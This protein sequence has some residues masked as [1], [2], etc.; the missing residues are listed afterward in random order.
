M[1]QLQ[2]KS[3]SPQAEDFLA[4]RTARVKS[5]P[6]PKQEVERLW[7]QRNVKAFREIRKTLAEMASGRQRCMYCEDSLGTDIEHFWPKSEFPARA[8]TWANYLWAC[9]HCNS[10][11]KRT[12]F[13]RDSRG[14]PLL[15]DPTAEEPLDH[16]L[17][18]PTT[19]KFVPLTRKGRESEEVFGLNRGVLEQ[20]RLDAW[21][22]LQDLLPAY[23]KFVRTGNSVE[24]EKRRR[25]VGRHPFS[26]VLVSLLRIAAGRNPSRV[27][28]PDCLAALREHPEIRSWI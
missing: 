26:S 24:A 11:E 9:S 8:F 3:L 10:N 1:R 2:R 20:G 21:V 28:H 12:S 25:A 14:R 4:K 16:L 17:L 5:S 19:G 15:I 6:K 27:I 23:A 22:A 18:S 13:P 7:R